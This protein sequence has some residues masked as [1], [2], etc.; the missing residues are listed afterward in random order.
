[1]GKGGTRI[2]G[3][4]RNFF[5]GI[6]NKEFLIF[7]FFLCVSGTF[8]LLMTLNETYEREV[9]LPVHLRNVPKGVVVTSEMEDTVKATVRDKGY[10]LMAY[11]YGN[12]ITPID[13]DYRSYAKSEGKV[14]VAAAELQRLVYARLYNSSKVTALKPDHVEF[15]YTYGEKKSLP[16]SLVGKVTAGQSYYIARVQFTPDHVNVYARPSLLD[17]L[18]YAYTQTLNI[19]GITDTVVRTVS[20]RKQKGVK[21]EPSQVQMTI[22]P[23]ILTESSVEVPVTAVNM[24][25]GKVLRTFPARVRVLFVT[26]VSNIRKIRPE[27]FR[28]VVDYKDI[29]AHP[30]DKCS[31]SLKQSPYG[32]RN[33]HMETTSVDYLIEEQ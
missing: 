2:L 25:A 33:P 17:S 14:A 10:F 9:A 18:R 23:D 20:L 4:F 8:W 31:L 12:V 3:L 5:F 16:L 21:F 6:V 24:P 7:L 27:Q 19:T 1:M 15:Y 11:A 22:Y 28:V 13:I 29:V 30:S 32:V 26:G